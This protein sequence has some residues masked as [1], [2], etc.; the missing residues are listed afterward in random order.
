A[1]AHPALRGLPAGIVS[2]LVEE[3]VPK[4]VPAGAV[5]FSEGEGGS[6][7]YFVTSGELALFGKDDAGRESPLG[8][9][10]P[11]E[12]AGE[13]AFLTG[14]PRSVTARATRRTE[15]LALEHVAAEPILRRHKKL[16]ETLERLARRRGIDLMLAMSRAFRTLA[17]DERDLVAKRLIPLTAKPGDRLVREGAAETDFFLLKSGQL[18]VT[19][20]SRGRQVLLALLEPYDCFGETGALTATPRTST[21]SALTAIE[22][23]ALKK[24]DLAEIVRRNPSVKSELDTIQMER[25]VEA[26]RVL[27]S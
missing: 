27:S 16:S 15:A 12:L 6:A 23:F 5:L 8:T 26:A 18:E 20:E 4:V 14:R 9:I 11:G 3:L 7:L 19:K 17:P 13:I 21:V 24:S 1:A 2:A 10:G 22:Y 25:F